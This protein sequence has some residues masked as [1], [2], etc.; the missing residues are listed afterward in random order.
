ML[1][2]NQKCI[3]YDIQLPFGKRNR[4]SM[5]TAPVIPAVV[6]IGGHLDASFDAAEIVRA[7]RHEVVAHHWRGPAMASASL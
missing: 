3:S 7:S 1:S 5:N 4:D 2:I 6:M